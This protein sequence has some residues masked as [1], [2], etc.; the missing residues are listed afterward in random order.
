MLRVGVSGACGRM[1][2]MAADALSGEPDV[3]LSVLYAPGHRGEHVAGLEVS[4]DPEAMSNVEVI[5]ELTRPDVVDENLR[6][7]RRLGIDTVVGTSGFDS[8]RIRGLRDEWV[9]AP[10]RCLIVP[11]FSIGAVLMMRFAETAAPYFSAAEVI[12]LHHDRKADAPSGTS[13]G[14]AERIAGAKPVQER[15]VEGTEDVPGVRG[16]S[17]GGVRVHSI[18]LPGLVAHQEVLLGRSGETLSLRHDSTDIAC[19][20]PGILLAVRKVFELEQPVTVG[21]E[22]LL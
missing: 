1:G 2:R 4:D 11:N 12:E 19:F 21:L 13:I 3:E 8:E 18:R 7:W 15:A 10:P 5:V 22:N 20:A 14:T 16:G 9:D 6:T 17:V